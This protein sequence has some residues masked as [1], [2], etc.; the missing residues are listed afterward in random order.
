MAMY[1]NL[2][3]VRPGMLD[4]L[5][6]DVVSKR[7]SVAFKFGEPAFVTPGNETDIVQGDVTA[8][9]L[10]F[11]GVVIHTY[12]ADNTVEG[13]YPAGHVVPT[14]RDGEVWVRVPDGKT[15]IFGKEAHVVANTGNAEYKKFTDVS[16]V[17][18]VSTGCTFTSNAVNLGTGQTFAKV[19]VN[20]AFASVAG[21]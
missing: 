19:M 2:D 4:G 5:D 15:T 10:V 11:Q 12:Y 21:T 17:T 6:H 9:T 14:C 3:A 8:T 13:E 16:A 18:T 20:G 1:G 7:A